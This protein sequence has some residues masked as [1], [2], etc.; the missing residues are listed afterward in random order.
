[1]SQRAWK[2]SFDAAAFAAFGDAMTD[3]AIY[4]PP[5]PGASVDCRVLVDEGMGVFGDDAAPVSVFRISVAF[6]L[7][8][9]TPEAGG[10]VVIDGT[11]FTL[12]QRLEKSDASLSYWGVQ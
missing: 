7:A 8:Q 5:G 3:A 12:V 2:Q 4:T 1:M 10:T 9:V 11:T 6:Q